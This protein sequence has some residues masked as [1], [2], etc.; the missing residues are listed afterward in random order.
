MFPSVPHEIFTVVNKLLASLLC[1]IVGKTRK[2]AYL[3][4]QPSHSI[5][6]YVDHDQ[7]CDQNVNAPG[8]STCTNTE[9]S[10]PHK[11]IPL[12]KSEDDF[13]L[14]E[15]TMSVSVQESAN[16]PSTP[17]CI[18]QPNNR[19]TATNNDGPIAGKPCNFM[20]SRSV[21]CKPLK[22]S[23]SAD[24]V[25]YFSAT[26]EIN[27]IKIG[28]NH[29][30][31]NPY[32]FEAKSTHYPRSVSAHQGLKSAYQFGSSCNLLTSH[33]DSSSTQGH[34]KELQGENESTDTQNAFKFT[35]VDSSLKK[36]ASHLVICDSADMQKNGTGNSTHHPRDFKSSSLS[37]SKITGNTGSIGK[38]IK[39]RKNDGMKFEFSEPAVVQPV[40]AYVLE[41][42]SP[43][44]YSDIEKDPEC[45]EIYSMDEVQVNHI[46]SQDVR[47]QL[48][49][50]V[51]NDHSE[52]FPNPKE[53]D[54][55]NKDNELFGIPLKNPEASTLKSSGLLEEINSDLAQK[56]RYVIMC[57]MFMI[58]LS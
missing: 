8:P 11:T 32:V 37:P 54:G 9:M 47:K 39:P 56:H 49:A 43:H 7:N 6:S 30:Q 26:P 44:Q 3:V 52:A 50:D 28:D 17:V 24:N 31:S 1:F 41:V 42:D 57:E 53:V 48:F 55:D 36:S 22:S 4:L 29:E 40:A 12:S 23:I 58:R 15:F 21:P 27:F 14:V 51:E 16:K 20:T 33:V 45:S 38:G 5:D 35:H 13:P 46:E 2:N 10:R 25:K 34:S 18:E 19:E